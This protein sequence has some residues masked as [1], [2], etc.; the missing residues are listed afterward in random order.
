MKRKLILF[1]ASLL[2]S[3]IMYAQDFYWADFD[4]HDYTRPMIVISRV[5]FNGELQ[6]NANVEVA[7]FVGDELRG[8]SFLLEP[9]PNSPI[10][11]QYFAYAPC[12]YD[13]P[14]ETFTFKAYDHEAGL[15]YDICSTQLVGQDDGYGSVENPIILNFTRTEEQTYG[16]EYPWIPSTAY[17]GEGMTVTAQIQ[18]NG[19]LVDRATYEVGAF[20]GEEC[21]ATSGTTLDDWTDVG[22][23]YFA[24]MNVMGNNGDQINFYLY[25]LENSCIFEGVCN[26]TITLQNGGELGIDI[27]GG[28][29]FVLNFVNSQS[30]TL[31]INPYQGE[32]D[33][34]Y[35]IASPIGA[36]AANAVDGL[37]TPEFDFY[38][39]NQSGTNGDGLE[40]INLKNETEYELQ[41]GIGYL[42]AHNTGTDLTFTGSGITE[43][44]YVMDLAYDEN[45]G[46]F[47]GWNLMGNPFCVEATSSMSYYRMQNGAFLPD[48]QGGNIA[49]MEGFFVCATGEGQNVTITPATGNKNSKLALNLTEDGKVIDR[50]IVSFGQ[51]QQ[52]PKL[53]LFKNSSKVYIPM[54]N[55]DYAIVSSEGMGEMPVSFKAE[56]NGNYTLS[57]N[58]EEVS[59]AYLHL[60]DNLTGNDQDML[61]NPSY[62]FNAQ[63]TDYASRFKL[64]FAT[65]SSTD[66]DT[67]AFFSNGSFIINNDGDAILQ[68][69]DVTGRI[70]SDEEIHG[71]YS[72]HIEAAPGVYMLRLVKGSDVKVQKIVVK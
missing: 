66:S 59:F 58:A 2:F 52:L 49:P 72:K 34:Y 3:G 44:S 33:N 20:C 5:Q 56:S 4:Y 61:A 32:K 17:S 22:L 8:R 48:L 43:G 63:T 29:I 68:V 41:P 51:S 37:Q 70:M 55:K 12:Y 71:C 28:D 35:L 11:G 53:Q 30:F 16:P 65:G 26:T 23:G 54:D 21:R 42:Y 9:Y 6:N 19:Q 39:F 7:A 38:S 64:V 10:A 67:F 36:V 27:F 15:E 69:V 50:A 60:I 46:D 25:D 31:E 62:T 1:V 47:P 18:I 13:S 57:L 24:F 45:A 40:W 14:G